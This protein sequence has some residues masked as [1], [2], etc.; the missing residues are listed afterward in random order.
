MS[1]LM[2]KTETALLYTTVRILH[3]I[4]MDCKGA[5]LNVKPGCTH[6]L[7]VTFLQIVL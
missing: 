4:K 3:D 6:T 1:V 5:L 2:T 7:T